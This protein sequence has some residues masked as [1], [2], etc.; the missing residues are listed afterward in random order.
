MGAIYFKGETVIFLCG[1]TKYVS[2][3]HYSWPALLQRCQAIKEGV[4]ARERREKPL[5]SVRRNKQI[6]NHKTSIPLWLINQQILPVKQFSL[7]R[8]ADA[9]FHT[10]HIWYVWCTHRKSET[11]GYMSTHIAT[12]W[13]SNQYVLRAHCSENTSLY[14]VIL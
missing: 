1:P 11:L 12:T 7:R 4:M 2:L 8:K 6:G 13:L 5:L 10:Y 3:L 9:H 14:N